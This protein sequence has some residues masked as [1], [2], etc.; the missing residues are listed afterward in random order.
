MDCRTLC[1]RCHEEI[2]SRRYLKCSIC[3]YC[4]DL[5]CAKITIKMYGLMTS[6]NKSEWKCGICTENDKNRPINMPISSNTVRKSV[7]MDNLSATFDSHTTITGSTT[8]D[9]DFNSPLNTSYNDIIE[10]RDLKTKIEL[11]SSKLTIAINEIDALKIENC[12][13]KKTLQSIN[14]R[15]SGKAYNVSHEELIM[16]TGITDDI[17]NGSNSKQTI[18]V[19][20]KN[21]ELEV[22]QNKEN[23]ESDYLGAKNVDTEKSEQARQQVESTHHQ[24]I[25]ILGDQQA[26]NVRRY[27][28]KLVGTRYKV[29][30]IWKTGA[31]VEDVLKSAQNDI[32]TLTKNDIVVIMSGT[33][34][35]NPFLFKEKFT[36]WL[37]SIKHTNILVSE[38][39]YNKTLH[40]SKLNEN[41]KQICERFDYTT[42]VN[43]N[44]SKTVPKKYAFVVNLCRY[45]LREILR[46]D[47]K[48]KVDS[49][50]NVL[51]NRIQHTFNIVTSNKST[52]TDFH[53]NNNGNLNSDQHFFRL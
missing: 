32:M 53:T 24:K 50:K 8:E 2:R 22:D 10:I 42:F 16:K 26:L 20:Q 30:S 29:I 35:V 12:T 49:Y 37:S 43:L 1:N 38:I 31:R 25:Y 4:Y 39:P 44:Y 9:G 5:S 27:L 45:L 28:Q 21:S 51:E 48:I 36:D 33:N 17:S 46:I 34:E 18:C 23:R 13:L 7:S 11:L 41:L 15:I 6:K 19:S 3:T 14:D 40:E 47:Y 52:Q